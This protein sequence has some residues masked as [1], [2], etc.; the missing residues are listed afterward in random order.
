MSVSLEWGVKL[1]AGGGGVTGNR[2]SSQG[3]CGLGRSQGN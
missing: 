3:D 2:G 1:R